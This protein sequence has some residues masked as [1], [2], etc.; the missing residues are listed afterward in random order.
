MPPWVNDFLTLY[1]P[2]GLGWVAFALERFNAWRREQQHREDLLAMGEI[3]KDNTGTIAN[4]SAR[5]FEG[6]SRGR[7]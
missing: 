1:G 4:F 6:P 2:L 5:L 3:V 7:G